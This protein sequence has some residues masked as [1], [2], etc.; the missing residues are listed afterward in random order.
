MKAEQKKKTSQ[1]GLHIAA[2]SPSRSSISLLIDSLYS[3]KV[4]LSPA[5]SC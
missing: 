1:P 4:L 2:N 3:S 5:K